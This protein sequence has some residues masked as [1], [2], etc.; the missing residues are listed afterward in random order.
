MVMWKLSELPATFLHLHNLPNSAL[1]NHKP[2]LKG[3]EYARVT[4]SVTST[5]FFLQSFVSVEVARPSPNTD[6]TPP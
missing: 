6:Q 3:K 1:A 5:G 4:F 2:S